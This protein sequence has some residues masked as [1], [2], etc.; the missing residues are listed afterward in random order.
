MNK[1]EQM[2]A[3]SYQVLQ[4]KRNL[5]D[6][7]AYSEVAALAYEILDRTLYRLSFIKLKPQQILILSPIP[8]YAAQ[9]VREMFPDVHLTVVDCS[10]P[11]LQQAAK[12]NIDNVSFCL[13]VEVAEDAK[14]DVVISH[15]QLAA[16]KVMPETLL[17]LQ[18]LL[19]ADGVLMAATF[20]IDTLRELAGAFAVIDDLQHVNPYPD[21]HDLGDMLLASGFVDPVVDMTQ[22]TVQYDSLAELLFDI[23]NSG[24]P[25]FAEHK[26]KGLYTKAKLMQV[27][28]AYPKEQDCLPATFEVIF[29][30]AFKAKYSNKKLSATQFAIDATAIPVRRKS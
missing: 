29:A 22:L 1:I 6:P 5:L 25:F 18:S 16:Q 8:A 14:F 17:L 24:M 13:P 10:K 28:A 15:M 21:M 9:T 12:L 19:Q 23:K 7:A 3:D 4:R 11:L 20:G 26:N 27:G 30:H 2:F